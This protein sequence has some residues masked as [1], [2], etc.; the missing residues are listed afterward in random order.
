M[1]KKVK[2]FINN[3]FNLESICDEIFDF[4]KTEMAKQ[5]F[6]NKK[7][8]KNFKDLIFEIKGELKLNSKNIY[9]T[10]LKRE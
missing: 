9:L 4:L 6:P 8:K 5:D 10:T 3:F 7:I 2:K 1:V